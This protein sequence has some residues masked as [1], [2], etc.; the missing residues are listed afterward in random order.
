MSHPTNWRYPIAEFSFTRGGVKTHIDFSTGGE[1]PSWGFEP[2][3]LSIDRTGNGRDILSFSLITPKKGTAV[4]RLRKRDRVDFVIDIDDVTQYSFRGIVWNV[5]ETHVF[6]TVGIRQTITC[7]DYGK[8]TERV[9]I[10]AP[11][12]SDLLE[13]QMQLAVDHMADFDITVHPDQGSPSTPLPDQLWEWFTIKQA[14][15]MLAQLSNWNIIW[16]GSTVE[17]VDA[18]LI[19]AP[20][21]IDD[22][23][24]NWKSVE[25]S[26]SLDDYFNNIWFRYG[27]NGV[28]PVVET[29]NGDGATVTWALGAPLVYTTDYPVV[30]AGYVIVDRTANGGTIS[31]ENVDDDPYTPGPAQWHYNASAN[32]FTQDTGLSA[33]LQ[34]GD[35]VTI[36][37]NGQFPGAVYV[38]DDAE[39][40]EFGQFTALVTDTTIMDADEARSRATTLLQRMTGDDERVNVYTNRLGLSPFQVLTINVDDHV[41]DDDY[42]ILRTRIQHVE[43]STLKSDGRMLHVFDVTAECVKGNQY[44]RNWEEF[45]KPNTSTPGTGGGAPAQSQAFWGCPSTLPLLFTSDWDGTTDQDTW[46]DLTGAASFSRTN[47]GVNGS[48]AA[49]RSNPFPTPDPGPTQNKDLGVE[50]VEGCVEFRFRSDGGQ[51]ESQL[52]GMQ[53]DN[54]GGT[55]NANWSLQRNETDE[56]CDLRIRSGGT[57]TLLFTSA[58]G[59]FS[60]VNLDWF[61]IEFAL[62][63]HAGGGIFN[64][65]GFIRLYKNG[66][67]VHQS[68][69]LNWHSWVSAPDTGMPLIQVR[70]QGDMDA[71]RVRGTAPEVASASASTS[72]SVSPSASTSPSHSVSP[73]GSESRSVSP[74]SSPSPSAGNSPSVSPSSSASSSISRSVSPSVSPSSSPSR[75]ASASVSPSSS[76][77]RS[78]SPSASQSPSASVSPSAAAGFPEMVAHSPGVQQSSATTTHAITIPTNANTAN[79]DL[80]GVVFTCNNAPTLSIASGTGWTKLGERTAGGSTAKGAIYWKIADGTDALS[81]G[82]DSSVV[83]VHRTFRVKTGTFN[84]AAPISGTSSTFTATTNINPSGHTPP[85]G[86]LNYLW[87]VTYHGDVNIPSAPPANYDSLRSVGLSVN[88]GVAYAERELNAA[89]EDPGAWTNPNDNAAAFVCAIEPV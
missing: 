18:S 40:D 32:T 72:A 60:R 61:R 53:Q 37:Y 28:Q 8:L 83:S 48:L 13:N 59:F 50:V 42:M 38:A 10:N 16:D 52:I 87:L 62:G 21:D 80:I 29:F 69:G 25:I 55:S 67:I 4:T 3:S 35:T 56:S 64:E 33:I 74:S 5:K 78:V 73:S 54:L 22:V 43:G 39:V 30:P 31:N 19:S 77:S 24:P 36:N 41:L 66:I 47:V 84:A 6:E 46:D 27:P 57:T 79:G 12:P 75:S 9:L 34:P 70:T 89:S 86:A 65:D 49:H 17:L 68:T 88:V 76:S 58:A 26:N 85:G 14:L 44:R 2:G 11:V 82:T 7:V 15:E 45:Y 51:E 1:D 71:V 81:I 63:A 23:E 20:F